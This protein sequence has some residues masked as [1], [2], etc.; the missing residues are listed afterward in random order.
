M[1]FMK[2]RIALGLA[3]AVAASMAGCGKTAA[4]GGAQSAGSAAAS[5]AA[6]G[7]SAGSGRKVLKVAF[8]C[9]SAPFCW[10]QSDDANGALPLTGT[11]EY[12]YGFDVEMMKQLC[13]KAGYEIEAYKI[14]W[15]GMLMGVQAGTYDC[16][17]SGISITNDRKLSMDFTDPYYEANIVLLTKADGKYAN[18]KTLA[19][20]KG[21]STTS[22]LN[23]IW[24]DMCSQ[25]P[26]AKVQPALENLPAMI[27]AVK[28]GTVDAITVDIPTAKAAL[29]SN[30]DLV[31]VEPDAADTF[32]VSSEDVD[33]GIAVTKGKEDIVKN[34]NDALASV[35]QADRD[36]ML[37]NA[38]KVQ[39]L[40][41]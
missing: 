14:D 16:A 1:V 7:E 27:V 32:R 4:S 10:T 8:E 9:Q 13:A 15:D 2:K 31:M 25:I 28:S 41:Q 35:S 18:A 40:A 39:P 36:A 19:D 38:I 26:D 34:L 11:D 37:D 22:M 17:I 20:F 33:L 12:T 6:G 3:C 30:P 23:T 29:L 21:C 5:S 24:Y